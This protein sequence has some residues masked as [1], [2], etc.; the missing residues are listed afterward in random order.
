MKKLSLK[1]GV[2]IIQR[3]EKAITRPVLVKKLDD[4]VSLLVRKRALYRCIRCGRFHG[5]K[6]KNLSASHYWS[7][8][9]IGT[10]WDLDNLDA[11]CWFPCH[12]YKLEGEKQGWYREYMIS[13]LGQKGFER[14]ELKANTRAGYSI[15]DLILLL[16]DFQKKLEDL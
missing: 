1:N 2:K 8:G 9:H 13:K 12:K 16:K 7:R 3:Q 4:V 10:R 15:S 6:S 5:P 14:L 11:A